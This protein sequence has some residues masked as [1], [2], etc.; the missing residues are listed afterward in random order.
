MAHA[1][2]LLPGFFAALRM[3]RLAFAVFPLMLAGLTTSAF[4]QEASVTPTPMVMPMI[5]Q[6]QLQTVPAYGPAPLTV[7]FFVS[8]TNPG[9]APLA[10]YIWNFGDGQVSMLPPT[11]LFHTYANPG[12]Y[13]VNVTATDTDGHQ[14][15]SFAG[16]IVTQPP[17]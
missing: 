16:V 4:A 9:G 1:S 2:A 6:I 10:S 8:S 3:T 11:A 17:H 7:G 5:P 13:V 15:S 12:S 14:A